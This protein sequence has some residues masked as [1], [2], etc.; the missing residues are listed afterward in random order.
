MTPR[1]R[2][3]ASS[4][5]LENYVFSTILTGNR[6]TITRK[7]KKAIADRTES[8]RRKLVLRRVSGLAL[9]ILLILV[10]KLTI[11]GLSELVKNSKEKMLSLY[12]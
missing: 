5:F 7:I 4:E 12:H 9:N 3:T 1:R 10:F 2:S 11:R 8:E 6:A